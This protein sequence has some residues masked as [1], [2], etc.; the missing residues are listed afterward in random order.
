MHR[1][2][3]NLS[4]RHLV[5]L[6][7]ALFLSVL[8]TPALADID[9]RNKPINIKADRSEFDQRQGKQ[10]FSG[11]VEVSQGSMAITA[12]KVVIEIRD[13]AFYRITGVG[14]PIRFQQLGNDSE[15]I[16]GQSR[17]IAYDTSSSQLTFEGNAQFERPGQK[18]SGE[19]IRYNMRN[20]TFEA[21]GSDKGRVSIILQ[22]GKPKQ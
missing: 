3:D 20:L 13:G 5:V 2:P 17:K 4:A 15:L 7:L 1:H 6:V 12:D 18:F 10:T 21:K 8:A 14:S 11:N 19:T 16:R 9:D 22:P